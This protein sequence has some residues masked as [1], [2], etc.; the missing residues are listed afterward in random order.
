[1]AYIYLASPYN[2]PDPAIR[3]HRY[4]AVAKATVWLLLQRRW[5]YSPIVHCHDLSI[6]YNLPTDANYWRTYNVAMLEEASELMI[7]K[8]P[9]WDTS[10]GVHAE[11]SLA[12]HLGLPVTYTE[13]S[14]ITI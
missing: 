7:L 13:P 2:D 1:M 11:K 12:H 4:Q 3:E 8:L 14:G 10:A 9:G 5:V 6:K